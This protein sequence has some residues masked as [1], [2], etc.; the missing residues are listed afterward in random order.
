MW[1]P[2][3]FGSISEPLTFFFFLSFLIKG[4]F[5]RVAGPQGKSNLLL[6][7]KCHTWLDFYCK[8]C[9]RL[10]RWHKALGKEMVRLLQAMLWKEEILYVGRWW[11]TFQ[12]QQYF[13][14]VVLNTDCHSF[15][16]L[17]T[18]SYGSPLI[19]IQSSM[20]WPLWEL[21]GISLRFDTR[22]LKTVQIL[23]NCFPEDLQGSLSKLI[24]SSSDDVVN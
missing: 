11:F 2:F 24:F 5:K 15:L 12:W 13:L 3:C 21:L 6:P 9:Q 18:Q 14:I 16:G 23:M 7:P 8:N 4:I 19:S 22:V 17:E 1:H 10:H 20:P